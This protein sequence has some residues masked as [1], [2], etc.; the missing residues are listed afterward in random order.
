MRTQAGYKASATN[1]DDDDD[2]TKINYT[3]DPIKVE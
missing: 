1:D 3:R 2:N